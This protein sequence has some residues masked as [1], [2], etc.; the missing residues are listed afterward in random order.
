MTITWMD[1]GLMPPR[2]DLLPED[3]PLERGGGV[4]F[5]GEKGILMHET[6]GGN[7]K[8]YPAQLMEVAEKVPKTFPRD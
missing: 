8:I 1:G 7:P 5:I 3:V 2:P 6:Y 4:I